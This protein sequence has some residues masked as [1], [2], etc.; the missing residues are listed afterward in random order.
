[1]KTTTRSTIEALEMQLDCAQR[2]LASALKDHASDAM[3]PT[4]TLGVNMLA[5]GII[6][7]RAS[8]VDAIASKLY[9]ARHAAVSA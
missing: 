6:A 8:K 4:N 1:M 5:A 7:D 3:R 9:S 2:A